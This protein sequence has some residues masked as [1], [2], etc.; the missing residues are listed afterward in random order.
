LVSA[1]DVAEHLGAAKD[2][3]YEPRCL[4]AHKFDRLRN[5]KLSE[6]HERV[7]S[8]GTADDPTRGER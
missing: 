7:R 8:E 3:V 2:S 6:V 1:D 5:C 4:S